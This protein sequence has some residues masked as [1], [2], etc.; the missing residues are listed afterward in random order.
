MMFK[1]DQT[2]GCKSEGIGIV[3][4]SQIPG[5]WQWKWKWKW[6]ALQTNI[7]LEGGVYK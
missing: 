6:K 4:L 1:S 7:T 3:P 5:I 2:S